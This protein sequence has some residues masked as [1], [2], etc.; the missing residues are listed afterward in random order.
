MTIYKPI[1]IGT[2]NQSCIPEIP[3]QIG[4]VAYRGRVT[5]EVGMTLGQSPKINTVRDI[6]TSDLDRLT[7]FL[8]QRKYKL[9]GAF[10]SAN[11]VYPGNHP[12]QFEVS[13]GNY[14]NKQ[15]DN[16]PA[17][18]STTPPSNPLYDGSKSTTFH[19]KERNLFKC[20][21]ESN[22]LATSLLY[23]RSIHLYV[24]ACSVS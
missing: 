13:I 20:R 22:M 8:C 15:D 10:F 19:G 24:S 2:F 7:P 17:Q 14:G 6:S 12:V 18:L 16:F 3:F 1:N 4:G 23:L 9:F 21:G 11:M 5:V